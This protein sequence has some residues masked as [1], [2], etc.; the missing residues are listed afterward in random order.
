MI[1]KQRGF[2]VIELLALVA[3][4]VIIGVVFWTQKTAIETSA[5]DDE[6]KT[7]INAFYFGLEEVYYPTNKNYPKTLSSS[8]LPSV[9]PEQFKDPQGRELGS[10]NS[11]YRYEGKNCTGD[12]C[13]SYSLRS[14]LDN[15]AD[16][17]KDSRNN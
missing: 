15:E 7:A 14:K 3:L 12:S 8:T 4:L 2:T 10:S 6:R 1:M 11:D 16:F 5:R 9:N 13:K 17:V